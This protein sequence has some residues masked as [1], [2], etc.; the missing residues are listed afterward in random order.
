MDLPP[1]SDKA[2]RNDWLNHAAALRRKWLIKRIGTEASSEVVQGA[3]T[4]TWKS[5]AQLTTPDGKVHIVGEGWRME[6]P[7]SNPVQNVV[8][9]DHT[10]RRT[11]EDFERFKVWL[12]RQVLDKRRQLH[13]DCPNLVVI[14]DSD[15]LLRVPGAAKPW[16]RM[17]YLANQVLFPNPMFHW[18]TG[19]GVNVPAVDQLHGTPGP[20]LRVY[21]NPNADHPVSD[22]VRARFPDG[23]G[24]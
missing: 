2:A 9:V 18:L 22:A 20:E 11:S 1:T 5:P 21:W 16:E 17:T 6:H 12:K 10:E 7:A 19:L 3:W 24:G 15:T 14:T 8:R 4:V 23:S 13:G